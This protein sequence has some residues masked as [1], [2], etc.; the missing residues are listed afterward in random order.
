MTQT[1]PPLKSA[2]HSDPGCSKART[3]LPV[4]RPSKKT[5]SHPIEGGVWGCHQHKTSVGTGLGVTFALACRLH[6]FFYSTR[7]PWPHPSPAS[8]SLLVPYLQSQ[9]F[10]L[11][12]LVSLHRGIHSFTQQISTSYKKALARSWAVTEKKS[13][14]LASKK[15][16]VQ[17]L[18]T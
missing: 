6:C 17:A 13:Q 5:Y 2:P 15:L 9:P 18:K 12:S 7:Q 8:L 16:M 3:N 4:G 10:Q 14:S 1:W 11:I